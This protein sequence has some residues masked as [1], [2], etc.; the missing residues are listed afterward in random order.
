M[1]PADNSV[2]DGYT[3]LAHLELTLPSYYYHDA[4]HY[5]H[6]LHAIWYR[7]RIYLCR[8]CRSS[9]PPENQSPPGGCSRQYHLRKLTGGHR[10][11]V[12][13]RR[14]WRGNRSR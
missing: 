11:D 5:E 3:G 4:A 8:L 10:D 2:S 6:E 13:A 12:G 1:T 7:N 9:S 14:R